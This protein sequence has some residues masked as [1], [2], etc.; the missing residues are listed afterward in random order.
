MF[1][2]IEV[3]D[4]DKRYQL[5]YWRE[6]PSLPLSIYQ[7]QTVTYGMSSSPFLANRT[8]LQ[9]IEDEGKNHKLA[10]KALKS[11]IYVDDIALGT[12]SLEHALKLQNDVIT[13]LG[14]GRF[15]L[16]KWTANH[17]QLFI[18]IPEDYHKKPVY[19]HSQEQPLVSVLGLQ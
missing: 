9:L 10:S 16:S 2:F 14:K 5:I 6:D 17:K 3:H 8:I 12:V 1:R 18:G 4:N 13:L 19:F 15:C 11:Q 7:L